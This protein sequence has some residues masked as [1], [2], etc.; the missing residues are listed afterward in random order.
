MDAWEN[1]LTSLLKRVHQYWFKINCTVEVH[2]RCSLLLDRALKIIF[3]FR[4]LHSPGIYI[5]L[6]WCLIMSLCCIPFPV[7]GLFACSR[8]ISSTL[9][10]DIFAALGTMSG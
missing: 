3:S 4:S 8:L 2:A 1:F 9:M 5:L 10:V 6:S 7:A